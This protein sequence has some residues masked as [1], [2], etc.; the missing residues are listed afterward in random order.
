MIT[1]TI[2]ATGSKGHHT[3]TLNVQ[4]DSTQNNSSFISFTFKISATN[5]NWQWRGYPGITYSVSINGTSYTGSIASF[6]GSTTTLKSGSNIEIPH[7][8]DGTKTINISFSVTDPNTSVSYTC[9]NASASDTME[10]TTLH[11]P[12]EITNWST[13]EQN[14]LIGSS[15]GA[16]KI[17]NYLSIKKD[18]IR[19]TTYDGATLSKFRVYN[20]T[21]LLQEV[22][23]SSSPTE[24]TTDFSNVE[25]QTYDDN[26][27]L[28]ANITIEVEDSMGGISQ[29]S[30]EYQ[31]YNYNLP[32]II[33]TSTNVKRNGQ[34]TGQVNLNLKATYKSGTIGLTTNSMTLEFAYWEKGQ[35]ESTTYYPIPSNQ[36]TISG[37]D[38]S[39]SGWTMYKNSTLIEDVS[40]SSVYYFKF[41]ITDAFGKVGV[42]LVQCV[43]GEY[44]IG[45]YKD[46]VD[47]KKITQQ[48]RGVALE[49]VVAFYDASGDN[50]NLTLD[51]D[52]ADYE[53]CRIYFRS[54]ET[55][56]PV[57]S[58]GVDNPNGKIVMLIAAQPY[59]AQG[60]V[61]LKSK[62][63]LISGTTI[64]N[65]NY[66]Q[67]EFINN[68][69]P[70]ISNSNNIY[71]TK[72]EF[73]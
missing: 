71:I 25:L 28:R 7:E 3:F 4:E 26:G 16:G 17:I 29:R 72:V 33:T 11:T 24:I 20:G 65:V 32:N 44:L 55:E 15:F 69:S 48:G 64:T 73:Y 35:T 68:S 13:S 43:K 59:S 66:S 41:K 50:A 36:I 62:K 14:S 22:S 6:N 49:P 19:A 37:D 56:E 30:W 40:P 9:G 57:A 52:S 8:S 1:K 70:A 2:K 21:Q 47:F 45:R 18:T 12:P 53:H 39:V 27:T 38:I 58:V 46:R 34:S 63:V 67:I 23:S 5:S 60:R 31:V 61:Y 54:N 42:A 51:Y 10:L